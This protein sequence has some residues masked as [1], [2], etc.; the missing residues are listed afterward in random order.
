MHS[1]PKE[2]HLDKEAAQIKTYDDYLRRR[3][4]IANEKFVTLSPEEQA[5]IREFGARLMS[6][7]VDYTDSEA[8][9]AAIHDHISVS[10][11]EIGI[12]SERAMELIAELERDLEEA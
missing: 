11:E 10:D 5:P 4:E 12:T 1:E 9:Q 2:T 7:P 6:G 8:L 3:Q